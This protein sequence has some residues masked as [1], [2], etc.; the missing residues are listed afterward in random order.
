MKEEIAQYR[1]STAIQGDWMEESAT[2]AEEDVAL[3]CGSIEW[4]CIL[5][6]ALKKRVLWEFLFEYA[7]PDAT[8][9]CHTSLS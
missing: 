6:E 2:T 9:S 7:A 4:W 5:H 1:Q 8:V 3:V